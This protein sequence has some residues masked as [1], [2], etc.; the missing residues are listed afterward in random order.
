MFCAVLGD[1]KTEIRSVNHI[2]TYS[3]HLI[4]EHH[5]IFPALFRNKGVEHYG[6]RRLFGTDDLVS[7]FLQ[8]AYGFHSVVDM[9]PFHAVFSS[10][11][12]FMDFCRRRY[13]ADAAKPYLV[14]LEGVGSAESRAY[15]VCAPY[16][17]KHDYKTGF[18]Q[19]LVFFGRNSA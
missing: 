6:S 14:Y 16:I 9:L 17:V 18:G 3:G 15:V 19:F 11:G 8:T 2:L 10:Q 12:G 5:G 7:G 1:L 13:S 4:S